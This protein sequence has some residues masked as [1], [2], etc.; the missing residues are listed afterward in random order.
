MSLPRSC[1]SRCS[2]SVKGNKSITSV[3]RQVHMQPP[4]G[5]KMIHL[6]WMKRTEEK[7]RDDKR[8]SWHIYLYCYY[9]GVHA[10][11]SLTIVTLELKLFGFS[12]PMSNTLFTPG[13]K[14][15]KKHTHTHPFT[16]ITNIKCACVR[17]KRASTQAFSA[18]STP[19]ALTSTRSFLSIFL[20]FLVSNL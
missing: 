3:R 12:R 15:K 6:L 17:E 16:Q 19:P 2:G 13:C 10:V 14:K 20:H 8:E 9:C 18:I 11:V 7:R 1:S 4:E 5:K